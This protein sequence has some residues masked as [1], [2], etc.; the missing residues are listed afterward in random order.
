MRPPTRTAPT[1]P[2]RKAPEIDPTPSVVETNPDGPMPSVVETNPDGPTPSVA[3]T[4][5]DGPTLPPDSTAFRLKTVTVTAGRPGR[6]AD[7]VGRADRA[8]RAQ[9]AGVA[10]R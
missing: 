7:R 6:E 8:G 3:E 10:I 5:P 9:E 2:R 4:G 1:R